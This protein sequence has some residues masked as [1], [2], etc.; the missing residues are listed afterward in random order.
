MQIPSDLWLRSV[1]RLAPILIVVSAGTA[2]SQPSPATKQRTTSKP[3]IL[4]IM[5]DD[6]CTRGF[7]CYGSRLAKLDPTPTL[8]K[9][10]SEG[11]LFENVFCTNSIC[12]PSRANI[13][14]GQYCQRN[15]VLDLYDVLG[16][17]KHYLPK[18]MKAAGYT[19]AVIGKWHLKHDPQHFDY[20]S[21]LPGQGR[22][23]DPIMYTNDG[24][25]KRTVRFDS[26]LSREVSVKQ[27]KGHSSDVITD[28]AIEWI[29]QRDK[30]KP[31]FLMQHYK[32][33][34]DMFRYA[35]RYKDY[36]ADVEIPEPENMYDQ[37]G[38]KFGSVATRG[39]DDKLVKVIGSSISKRGRRNYGRYYK[40]DPKLSDREFT[41]KSYQ[42][43]AKDYLRCIKGVDDNL[44]RLFAHL[45]KRG[46]MDNTIIIY[47]GDQGMM[48]GEHDYMDKRW[49]YEESM[50]MP[51]LIKSPG[52]TK[53]GSKSD[54]LINNTDFAP[55]ILALA[56]VETPA[57]MQG[58]SFA[59]AL[60]GSTEPSDW[61]KATYYR[62]WMHMA[63]G[64]NNPAH[65]GIRT[66]THKL[67]F[68]Y[69]SDFTDIHGGKKVSRHG[70]NRYW[71]DTPAAWEFYDLIQDPREMHNRYSD[72]DFAKVIKGMKQELR[73]LRSELGE[74]DRAYPKLQ[75]IISAHWDK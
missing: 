33:P 45:E 70:G 11:M 55:T 38:P 48:L 73:K 13:L 29:D 72:P 63:H 66:K 56:K 30:S 54:W 44:S 62:Y 65:F 52:R 40:I 64:H 34:H 23:F 25:E 49:M 53:A 7:G 68:F 14:T 8:D 4:F 22:Y 74:T 43:Y 15:G 71:Q 28:I 57:Y 16:S 24:G 61:R 10:A 67:I 9:L 21:V 6:H 2:Q 17:E 35:P 27:Y 46:L 19:T 75:K 39:V 60:D 5:S 18:E 31:F 59:A 3:N 12:T 69:G 1:S 42:L 26:T 20:Y 41:H 50:R 58:K 47:T 36:L 37:P 51:L 32:A